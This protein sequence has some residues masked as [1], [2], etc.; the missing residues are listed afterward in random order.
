MNNGL[1]CQLNFDHKIWSVVLTTMEVCIRSANLPV[2][3]YAL[4]LFYLLFLCSN[5]V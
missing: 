2:E 1:V 3:Q 4:G 5:A